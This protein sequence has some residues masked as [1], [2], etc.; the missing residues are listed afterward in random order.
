[1]SGLLFCFVKPNFI[2]KFSFWITFCV[3]KKYKIH[4]MCE[5]IKSFGKLLEFF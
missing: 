1:M 3:D 2:N 5:V 4:I